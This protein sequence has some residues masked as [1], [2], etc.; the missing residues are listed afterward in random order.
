MPTSIDELPVPP[1]PDN[2]TAEQRIIDT[3]AEQGELKQAVTQRELLSLLRTGALPAPAK[4]PRSPVSQ[5]ALPEPLDTFDL[6][7]AHALSAL[8]RRKVVA[9]RACSARVAHYYL[10]TLAF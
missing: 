5:W 2:R 1:P 4:I 7:H 10:R 6:A 3:L 9:E 8:V